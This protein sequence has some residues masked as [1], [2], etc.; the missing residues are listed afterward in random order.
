MF[1][2]RNKEPYNPPVF[3]SKPE[4]NQVKTLLGDGCKFEGNLYSP[5]YTKIEGIVTGNL[6]GESGL[7]IGSKGVIGGDISSVEV[8]IE[9][10][11]RGNIRAH[12][13]E[14]KKGGK[15][16]G[17]VFVDFI[18]IEYGA[19]FNGTCKINESSQQD[20]EAFETPAG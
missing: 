11:V 5:E 9:G 7:V 3:N 17:D 20:N 15:L 19:L 10:S 16:Y 2:Q 12:K 6:S 1:G 13:L 14:I 8:I 4:K 18:V